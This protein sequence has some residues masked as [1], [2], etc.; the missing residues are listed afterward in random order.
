VTLFETWCSFLMLV[1]PYEWQ[2][3]C[4]WHVRINR[5]IYHEDNL[6]SSYSHYHHIITSICFN[7]AQ[8]QFLSDWQIISLHI[9]PLFGQ[10][11]SAVVEIWSQ[12]CLF[13]CT[14]THISIENTY[15]TFSSFAHDHDNCPLLFISAVGVERFPAFI[16]QHYPVVF[17]HTHYNNKQSM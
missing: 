11:Q 3:L 16:L 1:K 7:S 14:H 8:S 10:L 2:R 9:K 13:L 6:P 4:S 12:Y 17:T 5:T 15:H